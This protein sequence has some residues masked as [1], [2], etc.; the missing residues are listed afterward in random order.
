MAVRVVIQ[1]A[2]VGMQHTD[3][4]DL[5]AEMLVVA[6]EV[7]QDPGGGGDQQ[8]VE[9]PLVMPGQR[10]QLCRQGEGH[11]KVLH[12]QQLAALPRQPLAGFVVLALGTAAVPA[13]ARAEQG[14]G[15]AVAVPQHLAG[16]SGATALDGVHRAPLFRQQAGAVLL[17][18]ST[19][20]ALDQGGETHHSLLRSTCSVLTKA[21]M[22]AA[23]SCSMVSVRWT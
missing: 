9:G 17:Q 1:L 13:G 19:L 18:Q 8:V 4:T 21:L 12:R 10:A 5:T 14:M 16:G 3:H 7:F 6:A 2:C 15:A 22:V 23:V 20:I 11:H